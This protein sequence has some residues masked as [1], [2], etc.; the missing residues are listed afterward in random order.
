MEKRK[1]ESQDQKQKEK[2]NPKF[3]IVHHYHWVLYM[4]EEYD[5]LQ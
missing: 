5:S 4:F 1:F 2:K 3:F